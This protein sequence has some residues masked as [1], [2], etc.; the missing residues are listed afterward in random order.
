M[1]ARVMSEVCHEAKTGVVDVVV[2]CLDHLAS[3][4]V[5]AVR[6]A[7]ATSVVGLAE[8]LGK[9]LAARMLT[10]IILQLCK[11]EA[12]EVRDNVV[13][14]IDLVAEAVGPAGLQNSVLPALLELCK[15]LKWRVRMAVISKTAMLAA[16]VGV[17][18]YEKRLQAA[19]LAAMTDHVFAIRER[20]CQQAGE[21][22]A[23]F[24]DKWAAETFFPSAFAIYDKTTNYL[25]RMTCLM[26]INRCSSCS[27]EVVQAHFLPLVLL[28]ATD[29]VANVRL[30]GAKTMKPLLKIVDAGSVAKM[31]AALEKLA[32]DVD[33]DAAF[34]AHEALRSMQ[35]K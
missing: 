16:R 29:D 27:A 13:A 28:A 32:K 11:D 2:P 9:D 33:A 5:Q 6:V 31:K 7:F 1:A 25:H 14:N 12:A 22:V 21:I 3:D 17:K 30:M 20:A 18:V 15:D 26:L 23:L 8:P 35:A 34:F 4:P 10:P 24:G 19:L